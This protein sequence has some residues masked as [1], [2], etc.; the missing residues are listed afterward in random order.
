MIHPYMPEQSKDLNSKAFVRIMVAKGDGVVSY[1]FS[2]KSYWAVYITYKPW[3]WIIAFA[4]PQTQ[5]QSVINQF[6]KNYFV[7]SFLIMFISLAVTIYLLD[8]SLKPIQMVSSFMNE[9]ANGAA[10]LSKRLRISTRDEM[11]NLA[12]GFNAFADHL[13]EMVVR[14]RQLVTGLG[15]AADSLINSSQ[16]SSGAVKTVSD[17]AQA[18]ADITSQTSISFLEIAAKARDASVMVTSVTASVE[19]LNASLHEVLGNCKRGG[20]ITQKA[21]V[22][23]R[24][25]EQMVERLQDASRKIEPIIEIIN[26]IAKKTNLLAVNATIEAAHAGKAG[27]G[28]AVVASEIKDLA[29]QTAKA[30]SQIESEVEEMKLVTA[31]AVQTI[32][33][34]SSIINEFSSITRATANA[35][36]IQSSSI[37]VIFGNMQEANL[38]IT[39]I[40]SEVEQTCQEA[41]NVAEK[42]NSI[43]K[44]IFEISQSTDAVLKSAQGLYKFSSELESLVAQFKTT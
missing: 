31:Q 36:E 23:A 42:T 1:D 7:L 24:S 40:A 11:G 14:I 16:T 41:G 38:S 27:K 4:T 9:M 37:R 30:T 19:Q 3:N 22:H 2:G 18:A 28:F 32:G 25:S 17:S 5:M 26:D 39:S 34:I 43:S 13:K 44:S 8:R 6:I 10:D 21:D 12:H 33:L 35:V 15:A 20:E 29:R